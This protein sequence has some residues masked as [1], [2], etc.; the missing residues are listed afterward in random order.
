MEL[1]RERPV[2]HPRYVLVS[3]E[4]DRLPRLSIFEERDSESSVK[5][6]GEWART[7]LPAITSPS[8]DVFNYKVDY[9]RT[10]TVADLKRVNVGITEEI[11]RYLLLADTTQSRDLVAVLLKNSVAITHHLKQASLLL[12]DA[13]S[14]LPD[15]ED[16]VAAIHA[17]LQKLN[18]IST[19]LPNF[20][21][22]L[23]VSGFER[24]GGTPAFEAKL[25]EFV[26]TSTASPMS[27]VALQY[28]ATENGWTAAD[29]HRT[30]DNVPRLLVIARSTSGYVFGGFTQA[31]FGGADQAFQS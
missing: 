17:Q 25:N 15:G 19:Q 16:A 18:K 11:P 26:A 31:G 23:M 30:C 1:E 22:Q 10:A 3:V 28:R 5:L 13:P 14:R 7:A 29:F 8:L 9:S 6:V 2:R 21:L 27:N 20:D 12:T 4:V 24:I